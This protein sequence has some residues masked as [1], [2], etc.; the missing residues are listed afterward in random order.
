MFCKGVFLNLFIISGFIA[1]GQQ[2]NQANWQQRVD[3]RINVSLNDVIK[4]IS[5][6]EEI[7]YYNQSPNNLSEI[8]FHL[9]PNAYLNN[10]TPFAKQRFENG[11][12]DFYYAEPWQRGKIDSLY[13]KV[14][15]QKAQ[16]QFSEGNYEI[17]KVILPKPLPAGGRITISTSFRVKLPDIFSRMGHE[18]EVFCITQWYPKPAVYDV[19][20]WNTMPYLDQGEFYSEFGKYDVSITLPKD[21]VVAATGDVQDPVESAWWLSRTKSIN[22]KHPSEFKLKTVRFVQDSVHDFAWFA[23]KKFK[24]AKSKVTLPSGKVVDTWLFSENTDENTTINGTEY[25]DE[26]I[27]FYSDKVGEYPYNQATVVV[28]PL[29]AG[30]GM[31]YPTITNVS[32]VD[33]GVIVHEVGHNWFYGILGSNERL[34]PWMDESIN[35]Y[36]EARSR[37]KKKVV[38]HNDLFKKDS[39]GKRQYEINTRELFSSPFSEYAF[40]YVT[41]GRNNIDQKAFLPSDS[42]TEKNYGKIIYGKASV[43]F[44]QLQSYLGDD[45]FDGMM[46]S[47]YEKWKFKHPLPNDFIQHATRFTR[48]DLSWFFNDLMNSTAKQDFAIRAITETPSG[49]MVTVKNKGIK[50]PV[51]IQSFNNGVLVEE[52]RLEPFTGVQ[53]V[54]FTNKSISNI[55]IDAYE[56]S[57]DINRANNFARTSGWL[58]TIPKIELKPILNLEKPEYLQ[59]FYS[60]IIG[61]NTNNK[62][63]LGVAFYNSLLPR[64]RTE[65]VAA[66]MYAF[67][68]K[69]LTGYLSLQ[70]RLYLFGF[71]REIRFGLDASRFGTSGYT[72]NLPIA[73]DSFGSVIKGSVFGLRVYEKVAPR[74]AFVFNQKNPRTDAHREI[75]LRYVLTNEQRY[76]RSVLKNINQHYSYLIVGYSEENNVLLNKYSWQVNYQLGNAESQFQKI[77]AEYNKYINYGE[78]DKGLNTRVFAG[79]FLQKPEAGKDVF[80]NF[81]IADNN[82]AFDYLYDES[83]FGRGA[84]EIGKHNIFTQQLMPGGAGFRAFIRDYEETDSWMIATNFT[85]TIP[86]ILPIKIF[87]DAAVINAQSSSINVNTG[88]VTTVYESNIYYAT[89]VSLSLFKDVFLVNFPI[90]VDSKMKEAGKN[91]DY[92]QKMTFTLRLNKLSPIKMAREQKLF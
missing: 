69:D 16:I 77:Y 80:A 4:E 35:N 26:A 34:Y 82:G 36:Y 55:T 56:A 13:F 9:W 18:K 59:A 54:L 51:Q 44:S 29:K 87:V 88:V 90:F 64:K 53:Q 86:G 61:M 17:C 84:S 67:G 28:T 62:T 74:V 12:T 21:Y 43:A 79:V 6:Y 15:G 22:I 39:S 11:A 50:A 63:M 92:G 91:Y 66:P 37:Y 52:K 33:R 45:V 1:Q 14:D 58:K 75:S 27:T 40:L 42:F 25:I 76:T 46:K 60:P 20:G 81:R 31:E 65:F 70:H 83:Q 24:T 85:S 19:N 47:Y 49:I 23:S 72:D 2:L 78:K 71:F 68:T 38:V 73:V 32:E 57:M 3:Y 48:K 8:Y 89:G 30:G 41:A 5:G 7:I 10:E